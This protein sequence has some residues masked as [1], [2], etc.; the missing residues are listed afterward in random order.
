[1]DIQL[2]QHHLLKDYFCS[3]KSPLLLCG[4]S[5]QDCIPFPGL[6]N[7]EAQ[8][9]W[10]KTMEIYSLTVLEARSLQPRCLQGWTP[11]GISGGDSALPLSAASSSR[12]SLVCG[13]MTLISA[14]VFFRGWGSCTHSMRKFP[15]QGWNPS[16]SSDNTESLTA[17][18]PGNSI[19]FCLYLAFSPGISV[20]SLLRR[21][22]IIGF[23]AYS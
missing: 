18:S 19:C 8:T 13:S 21:I 11:P 1:M 6:P 12:P 10:L 22:P 4:K 23:R 9:W 15:G 5:V 20:S 16:H 7:K 17:R 14:S 3:T 2:S